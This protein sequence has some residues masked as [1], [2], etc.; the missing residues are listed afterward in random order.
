MASLC[1]SR[2]GY[3]IL[4]AASKEISQLEE[5]VSRVDSK[6][7]E[8]A[9]NLNT[10]TKQ[11]SDLLSKTSKLNVLVDKLQKTAHFGERYRKVW[12]NDLPNN[13]EYSECSLNE[14]ETNELV[15]KIPCRQN[16]EALNE[17]D[18]KYISDNECYSA[19]VNIQNPHSY[20]KIQTVEP[21]THNAVQCF[22]SNINPCKPFGKISE[23]KFF[24]QL[25]TCRDKDNAQNSSTKRTSSDE[26]FLDENTIEED[27]PFNA[28]NKEKVN[29]SA[30]EI[31]NCNTS[32]RKTKIRRN[33]SGYRSRTR[34]IQNDNRISFHN[35]C[36]SS[37]GGGNIKEKVSRTDIQR[38]DS[39][40]SNIKPTEHVTEDTR[41][42][43]KS[44][45]S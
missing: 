31:D 40:V 25:G 41:T 18:T 35:I 9:N 34:E 39:N 21:L 12:S 26:I 37:G 7:V 42:M 28:S 4:T 17:N 19:D 16:S 43:M 24:E 32:N 1:F 36:K 15:G 14:I 45:T 23:T 38:E 20:V 44:V 3:S 5:H 6:S 2:S 30:S 27:N 29:D 11:I 22:D 8:Y 33:E 10:V 13:D